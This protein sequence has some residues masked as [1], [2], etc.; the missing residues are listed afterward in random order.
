MGEYIKRV[1]NFGIPVSLT[2]KGDPKIKSTFGGILTILARCAIIG[3]FIFD[4]I[5]VIN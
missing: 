4:C 2:Y 5:A 1:D 3:Y